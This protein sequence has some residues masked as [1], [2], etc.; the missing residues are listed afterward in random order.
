MGVNF[1]HALLQATA[2]LDLARR[3]TERVENFHDEM[4]AMLRLLDARRAHEMAAS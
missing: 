2:A 4:R 1:G 3:A